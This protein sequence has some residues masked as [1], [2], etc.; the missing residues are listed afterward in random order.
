M[1]AQL[2]TVPV[3]P[4]ARSTTQPSFIEAQFPVSKLSKE[5]YNER[6]AVAGQTL[7]A[8]GKWWG[9]K[10]LVLVRAIILGLLLPATDN[11]DADRKTFLAL[12]TMDDDGMLRRLDGALSARVVYEG[13][14]P[15]ERTRYFLSDGT[16][17]TWRREIS[18]IDRQGVMRRAFLRMSYDRRLEYCKR[19]EEIDGPGLEAWE[20]INAHL[21]TS[22]MNLPEL[23]VE[24]GRRRFG[25]VPRVGDVFS[26]G[27]SIPFEAARLG[28]EAYGSDLNPVAALLT[29]GALNIV[30]GGEVAVARV[31]AAQ[32]RVF[33]AVQ[34][35]VDAW[36]IERNEQ[37]WIADAYLI[38]QRAARPRYRLASP[39]RAFVG[40]RHKAARHCAAGA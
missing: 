12:M 32:R 40:H 17:P 38:L 36:G 9:R 26:G 6:K 14:T 16:K 19:P 4:G 1:R 31:A 33:D 10:P 35:Q 2:P 11:P 29:W 30:G 27:G 8:L 37:G 20:R 18:R 13:C 21:G 3:E 5:S 23:V 25:G 7:T 24:L 39:A 22:A 34:R 28:C 15:R